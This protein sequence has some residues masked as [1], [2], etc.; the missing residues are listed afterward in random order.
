MAEES[1][2]EQLVES[3]WVMV[4][5]FEG[6]MLGLWRPNSLVPIPMT[7]YLVSIGKTWKDLDEELVKKNVDIVWVARQGVKELPLPM[8]KHEVL[9]KVSIPHDSVFY[10]FWK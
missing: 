4:W 6:E 8:E 9:G 10:K 7:H 5:Y 3:M 2:V 1:S